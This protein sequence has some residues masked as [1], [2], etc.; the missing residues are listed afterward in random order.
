VQTRI[1]SE[2]QNRPEADYAE[3]VLRACVHCGFCLATCPTYQLLGSELDSP[4]GR[5]YLLKQL[6][7]GAEVTDRTRLHLDRCLTCRACESTCPSGV[8]YSRLLD[9]GRVEIERKAPRSAGSRAFRR[10]LREVMTRRG[11]FTTLV[12]I[13]R[14]F[15][16][17]LPTKL[18]SLLPARSVTP[19]PLAIPAGARRVLLLDGCV[20]PALAPQ[21]NAAAQRVFARAGID[22][23]PIAQAGC[24]GA[25]NHHMGAEEAAR[26]QARTNIDAWWPEIEAGV[27][28]ICITAS[29]CGAMVKEYDHLLQHDADYAERATRIAALARDPA[30][31]LIDADLGLPG[32]GQRLAFHAPC[33]LQHGQRLPGVTERLLAGLGFELTPVTDPHLCCGSAGTYSLFQPELSTALRDRKLAA[34]EEPAPEQI[35]TANIG[36]MMHLQSGTDRPVRHWLQIVDEQLTTL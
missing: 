18:R 11:L 31:L 24:C 17:L 15:R 7:E 12:S 30:E 6:I 5:I 22:L 3:Q 34:L 23:Q 25:I 9:F 28:G 35:A 2:Y 19:I 14:P 26:T 36:C 1:A 10:I 8:K 32:T 13:G 16:G 4:R 33:T 21:I 27:E 20:Q 29:G